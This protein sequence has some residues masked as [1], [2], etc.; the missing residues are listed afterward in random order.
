VETIVKQKA[1]DLEPPTLATIFDKRRLREI[2]K[3]RPEFEPIIKI[4]CMDGA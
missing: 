3:I 2:V 4:V 1:I